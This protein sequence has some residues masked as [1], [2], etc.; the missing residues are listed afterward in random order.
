[1][2]KLLR[3]SLVSST[4]A[5]I[6]CFAATQ[7]GAQQAP[8]PVPVVGAG[9]APAA[10]R[11]ETAA[12]NTAM[13]ISNPEARVAALEKI[14]TDFPNAPATTLN[15]VDG[16]ILLALV[17]IPGK[18]DAVGGVV[19]RMLGRI[20]GNAPTDVRLSST[21]SAVNPL[22]TGKVLLDRAEKLLTDA[23]A[24]ADLE[25]FVE[26]R[27]EAA[28]L[29]GQPEPARAQLE[30]L[31]NTTKARGLDALARTYTA[32]G[33]SKR[34]EDT[35]REAVKIAPGSPA[36]TPYVAILVAKGDHAGAEAVLQ[37]A[38]KT[39]LTPA[40]AVTPTMA[41]VNFYNTRNEPAKA[42]PLLKDAIEAL[43]KASAPPTTLTMPTMALVDVYTK[44]GDIE[45]AETLL[46]DV[47]KTNPTLAAATVAM[48]KL[49]DK[50]GNTQA[51]LDHYLAAASTGGLRGPDYNAMLALYTKVHGSAA[52]L[53]AKLDDIYKVKFPNPVKPEAWKATPARSNRLVLLE[54]FTGSGCPPCVAADLAF[55]A[56][57]GRYPAGTAIVSLAYHVHIPQ[58]DPMTTTDSNTRRLYYGVTGVPT[59]EIDGAMVAGPTGGNL[60]GGGRDRTQAVYD[61]Y[62]SRIEKALET[63]AKADVK[64]SATG[65]GDAI[66]VTADVSNLPADAKDLRLHLVL[67]EKHLSF[68]G[69]NGIRFHP[70]V[71]RAVAGPDAAGLPVAAA[72][73][74]KHTFN[75]A[76]IREDIPKNLA[77]DIERRRATNATA[78]FNA[79]GRAMIDIDTSQLVVVAY[80]QAPDKSVLQAAQA[81]VAFAG[82]K[83]KGGGR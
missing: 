12:L 76:A 17:R 69:E 36:V 33:D 68:G 20:P 18:V 16:Q 8:P 24:A 9:Q 81:D 77:A 35:Y 26:A 47:I 57:M 32:K 15:T 41:L 78:S 11:P 70:V 51:A 44:K 58:P 75:L 13:A 52:G 62:T 59:F 30:L 22:I 37:A 7:T 82:G 48:A 46:K 64:V 40:A 80:V 65:A 42:E 28:R 71:V 79:D 31:F 10:P 61:A 43:K 72:G 19:D 60:G 2:A 23:I 25:K 49:E 27:T 55:D 34:A 29:L 45:A 38:L 1:M 73:T 67:A 53:E 63:A 66:T 50:K 5:V 56:V 21:I 4:L 14:L 3:R 74:F 6:M 39:A 83:T 54:M